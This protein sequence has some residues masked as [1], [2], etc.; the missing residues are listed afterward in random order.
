MMMWLW[1]TLLRFDLDGANHVAMKHLFIFVDLDQWLSFYTL[2]TLLPWLPY[3]RPRMFSVLFCFFH[4]FFNGVQY[5]IYSREKYLFTSII[6]DEGWSVFV[7]PNSGTSIQKRAIC[8]QDWE[9]F[10]NTTWPKRG[11]TKSN[12]PGPQKCTYYSILN[13][14]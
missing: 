8:F 4:S 1:W 14:I 6:L 2:I 12:I 9:D 10:S 11:N 5:V 7:H 3:C 13:D